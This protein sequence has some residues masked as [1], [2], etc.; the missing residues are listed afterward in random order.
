[1]RRLRRSRLTLRRSDGKVFL[2]RWGIEVAPREDDDLERAG[3]GIFLHRMTAP[4]P[5]IDL[6]DHPWSFLSVVLSGTYSEERASIRHAQELAEDPMFM[7]RGA[8]H[9]RRR[10]SIR[11]MRLDEAHR[12]VDVADPTWTLVIH[13]PE[14]RLWGFYT[15]GGWVERHVYDA[16]VRRGDL[17]AERP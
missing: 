1:M 5:G 17:R 13:A 6:H 3:A 15:P 11:A 12:V 9:R 14:R 7:G 2:D 16:Q 4:D 10:F 8:F